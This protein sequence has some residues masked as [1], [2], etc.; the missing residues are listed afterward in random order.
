M[1]KDRFKTLRY[2]TSIQSNDKKINVCCKN[3]K[4]GENEYHFTENVREN[5]GIFPEIEV[6]TLY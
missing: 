4:S 3:G 1:A 2:S 6:P 5:E